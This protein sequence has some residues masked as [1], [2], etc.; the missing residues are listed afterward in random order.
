L[1]TERRQRSTGNLHQ[2][3]IAGD[4]EVGTDSIDG[5]VVGVGSLAIHTELALVV[6][7]RLSHDHAR[8]EHDQRLKTPA[9]EGK[10]LDKLPVN[11]R[12]HC[13]RLGVDQ[14]RARFYS[15]RLR[16]GAERHAEIDFEPVLD[17]KDNVGL[18]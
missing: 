4:A 5:E 8:R 12:A 2:W 6:K 17:V 14:S 16:R 11:Y 3:T 13:G 7:S 9:V 15:D 10:I 1:C 18:H